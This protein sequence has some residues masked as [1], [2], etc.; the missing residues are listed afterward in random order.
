VLTA[1]LERLPEQILLRRRNAALLA[2]EIAG[3]DGI[4]LQQWPAEAAVHS[5]YL[6]LARV[7]ARR[8][9]HT[10]DEF[11]R[12]L[13]S[14]GVPCTPFYPHTLYRNPLY[15]QGG[16]RVEPCPVAEQCVRD[17]FWLPHRVLMSPPETIREIAALIREIHATA[18]RYAE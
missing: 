14:R 17:A 6:Q 12:A 1:Q 4:I 9:G 13:T 10:R 2:A 18:G 5:H 3:V 7:D 15:R 16:C 11:H 8:F